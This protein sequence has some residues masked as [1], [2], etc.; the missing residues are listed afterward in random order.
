MP[1]TASS[2]AHARGL[3][4]T[5]ALSLAALVMYLPANL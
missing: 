4:I 2:E 5:A 1:A 3:E